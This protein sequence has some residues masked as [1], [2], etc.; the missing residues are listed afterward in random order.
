M[1]TLTIATQPDG[2]HDSEPEPMQPV[3]TPPQDKALSGFDEGRQDLSLLRRR[4]RM[5][6]ILFAGLTVLQSGG[7]G[8]RWLQ[9]ELTAEPLLAGAAFIQLALMLACMALLWRRGERA[10]ARLYVVGSLLLASVAFHQWGLVFASRALL[11]NLLPVLVAGVLLG[12]R[13]LWLATAWLVLSLLIGG[14]R[15]LGM[16]FFSEDRL[17]PL[18]HVLLFT[19]GGL[20]LVAVVLDQTLRLLGTT[21]QAALR[22]GDALARKR[23]ELQLEI[24]EKERSREQLVHAMK[25][26]N[27]GHLASGVAHDF[28]HLLAVIMAY[29]GKGRRSDDPVALQQALLGV[30][31][32]ARRAGAVSRRLLDFSRQEPARPQ[33]LDAAAS[34]HAIE[35]VLRQLFGR[36]VQVTVDTADVRCR[37]LFDP[38]LLELLLISIAANA[39]EAM[40]DGGHFDLRLVW[41]GE[42]QPLQLH[43]RDD[44][45]GMS[46]AVRERC[47]EPFFTTKP[48]GQ[49]TGL[50][51]PVCATVVANAG[52]SISVHSATGQGTTFVIMLPAHADTP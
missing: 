25:M 31:A 32:A 38:A 43:L 26:E 19:I 4:R 9:A 35:P 15:D 28:N 52:G 3:S 51:L 14:W 50:G 21:L 34:I 49:G 46:E 16:L 5:L 12:R 6:L 8:L 2:D 10:A 41:P 30:E 44:G 45:H 22:R 39:N 7:L 1:Q 13:S 33:L 27:V 48:A 11:F 42:G 20:L 47:L 24:Q 36:Q 17:W 40:P 29:A 23:D 37:I 18:L